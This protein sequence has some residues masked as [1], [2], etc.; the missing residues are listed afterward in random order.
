MADRAAA[1]ITPH[2]D[3]K[4]CS[5]SVDAPAAAILITPHGD[6]K[7]AVRPV[8]GAASGSLPLMGIGNPRSPAACI[9]STWWPHYPS[10]GSETC[11]V[12]PPETVATASHYPSWGSE[13]RRAGRGGGRASVLITP[14]GDRKQADRACM[15][16]PGR[17]LITPHGDRKHQRPA[18]T[19]RDSILSLPLMGIGNL[20]VSNARQ[21]LL[22]VLITPHGDRKPGDAPAHP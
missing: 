9:G 16:R 4:R 19:G 2:G 17:M 8:A 13:T 10:W 14:H 7:P 5:S 22:S 15:A 1:L 21:A 20:L 18:R 6:R 11:R 3:R 12:L